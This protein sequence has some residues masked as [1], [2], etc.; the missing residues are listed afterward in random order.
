[1]TSLTIESKTVGSQSVCQASFQ[2]K[3]YLEDLTETWKGW[4][5]E[6]RNMY[7]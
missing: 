3:I 7:K 4:F 6:L 1:M 2:T 5:P